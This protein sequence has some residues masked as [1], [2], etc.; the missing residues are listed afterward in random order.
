M[1]LR[2]LQSTEV[3]TYAQAVKLC[4]D[5]EHWPGLANTPQTCSCFACLN[6]YM[7]LCIFMCDISFRRWINIVC[8]DSDSSDN[9][10]FVTRASDLVMT[11]RKWAN[12]LVIMQSM[13]GPWEVILKSADQC[14]MLSVV[15]IVIWIFQKTSVYIH[16][17]YT[18]SARSEC[19]HYSFIVIFSAIC[20][21]S[22][23]HH[24]MVATRSLWLT[25]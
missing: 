7:M 22:Y 17:Q 14:M 11:T 23:I 3:G 24:C 15:E 21:M 18:V 8:F 19:S 6:V 5:M 2:L 12:W 13:V 20:L 25:K 10:A 1:F 16:G 9:H 4:S